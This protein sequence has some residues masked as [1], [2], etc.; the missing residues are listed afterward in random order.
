VFTASANGVSTARDVATDNAATE[1][2]ADNLQE[3]K[4]ALK[5]QYWAKA[6][7]VGHRDW[8]K[9]VSKLKNS[10]GQY[11]WQPGLQAGQPDRLLN[12]PVNMSEFAPNTFTANLYVAVLGDFS[13]YWIAD[14]LA[15]EIQRLDELY[16]ATSQTGFK[17]ETHSD[18]MP[19]LAEAFVRSK[20][21]A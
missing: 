8:V 16:A 17:I 21:G 5:G 7:W 13:N 4:Y 6:Q 2:A 19:V 1:I 14:V 11:L 18:G 3:C 10:E 20:M 9:R 12:F 15:M